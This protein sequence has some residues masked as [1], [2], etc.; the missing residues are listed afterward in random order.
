MIFG[1][2]SKLRELL[3]IEY[4]IVFC[5]VYYYLNTF[6]EYD[7]LRSKFGIVFDP[8]TRE[9]YA[10]DDYSMD[11]FISWY[12]PNIPHND[13]KNF[14]HIGSEEYWKKFLEKYPIVE[15]KMEEK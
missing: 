6:C 2:T 4:K 3:P 10:E 7:W 15:Y 9:L 8:F 13:L 5:K 12:W 1:K 14:M 11:K